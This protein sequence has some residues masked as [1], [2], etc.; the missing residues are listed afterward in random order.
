MYCWFPSFKSIAIYAH[1]YFTKIDPVRLTLY[2]SYMY[3]F[4][5]TLSYKKKS[6][7][8]NSKW[9]LNLRWRRKESRK[10]YFFEKSHDFYDKLDFSN[11]RI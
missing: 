7:C 2:L 6:K 5:E 10:I 9:W 11:F 1:I 4:L 3:I 8:N